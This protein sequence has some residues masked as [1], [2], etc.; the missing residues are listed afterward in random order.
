MFGKALCAAM[1][2]TAT[3]VPEQE[4]LVTIF[5]W[6]EISE[7]AA[8]L[9]RLLSNGTFDNS[10]LETLHSLLGHTDH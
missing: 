6:N 9:P 4:R 2:F 8:L 3:H 7:G 10:Y 1:N 5:A